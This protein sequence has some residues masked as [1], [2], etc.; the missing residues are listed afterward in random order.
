MLMTDL[1]FALGITY[2][3]GEARSNPDKVRELNLNVFFGP[4]PLA[5]SS[6]RVIRRSVFPIVWFFWMNLIFANGQFVEILRKLNVKSYADVILSESFI[7]Y[8]ND[9]FNRTD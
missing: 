2:N 6:L 9:S 5:I 7:R 4:T 8:A 3:F 1:F